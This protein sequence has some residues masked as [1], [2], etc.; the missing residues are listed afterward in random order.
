MRPRVFIGS[1]SESLVV[2]QALQAYLED[3]RNY[4]DAESY[5]R[6][7]ADVRLWTEDPIFRVGEVI[8]DSLSRAT[9]EFDFAVMIFSGDDTVQSRN[10]EM[11]G[12]R[13]NVIFEAGLFAGAIG[14][15]R[16][17]VLTPKGV[18]IRVPSDL[19]GFNRTTYTAKA[20][21]SVNVNVAG[22]AIINAIRAHGVMRHEE[23]E[24]K[25]RTIMSRARSAYNI[26][27]ALFHEYLEHWCDS[28]LEESDSW[29]KGSMTIESATARWLASVFRQ[30]K[31]NIFSTSIPVYMSIWRGAVGK[32]LLKAQAGAKLDSTRVFVFPSQKSVTAEDRAVMLEHKNAGIQVRTFYDEEILE[33]PWNP[34]N[35]DTDFTFIDD[36][37][38]IGV[39]EETR[40]RYR[41]RWFFKNREKMREYA[42]YK[43]AL[44]NFSEEF[45]YG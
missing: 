17:F 24:P 13:D 43:D 42:G 3:Q 30:A 20:D 44:M 33:F 26:D 15:D 28:G 8:Q 37:E 34:G 5:A 39:T 29:P 6:E 19:A 14:F 7:G 12:P 31:R 23:I 16:L 2:A 18:H 41:S 22:Q 38:V 10:S 35:I 27:H 21:Q 1:S 36:G 45:Q 9:A 4:R 25:I 40:R 32:Q 11:Q